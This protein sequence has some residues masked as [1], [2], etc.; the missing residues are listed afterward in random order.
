MVRLEDV[1]LSPPC[2]VQSSSGINGPYTVGSTARMLFAVFTNVSE[3]GRCL[4]M[5][6]PLQIAH[7]KTLHRCVSIIAA[8]HHGVVP[9]RRRLTAIDRLYII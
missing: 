7:S 8:I 6:T 1:L 2:G 5:E 9:R 4:K 3:I